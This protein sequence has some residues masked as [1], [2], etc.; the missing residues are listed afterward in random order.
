MIIERIEIRA[1]G[2]L[3]DVTL[4]TDRPVTLV[5]GPNEA[6]KS[7]VL[8]FIRTMLFG[9]AF[10][11]G[12][13]RYAPDPAVIQ[14]GALTLR[15]A[16]GR[17]IRVERWDRSPDG[18]GKSP[19]AGEVKVMFPD[20]TTGGEREL[21][22]LVGG[23][24]P[25]LFRQ[26]FAFG[27]SELQ[28][29][30]TLQSEE[31]S[32]F[33]Y[34][35]GLGLSGTAIRGAQKKL[36]QELEQL[37]RPRGRTPLVNHALRELAAV[38]E[39]LRV[40]RTEAETYRL[41]V[42]DGAKLAERCDAL[43]E[44]LERL[45]REAREL[46]RSRQALQFAHRLEEVELELAELPE[47]LDDVPEDAVLREEAL[48][49]ELERLT[50]E[51]DAV[52]LAAAEAETKLALLESG[53]REREALLARQ[54]E[55]ESLLD[56]LAGYEEGKRQ[57]AEAEAEE[58]QLGLGLERL[59]RRIGPGWTI[60]TL[61][62]LPSTVMLREQAAAYRDE[63]RAW[64][65]EEALIAAE[66]RR[67]EAEASGSYP[68]TNGERV[69]PSPVMFTGGETA[70]SALERVKAARRLFGEWKDAQR[71]IRYA[72]QRLR[73]L[74]LI[75]QG[76]ANGAGS[77]GLNASVGA[78]MLAV[79]YALTVVLPAALLLLGEATA[80][81]VALGLLLGASVWAT[82]N[83]SR[84]RK[85]ERPGGRRGRPYAT[86]EAAADGGLAPLEAHAAELAAKLAAELGRLARLGLSPGAAET[87]AGAA[88]A[89]GA[90]AGRAGAG[91][92][93][94]GGVSAAGALPLPPE[95]IEPWLDAL[96]RQLRAREALLAGRHA[97][98]ER[99]A[100]L[101][102][103]RER[104][105]LA[106]EPLAARWRAW[107]REQALPEAASA[108][109][110]LE[111]LQQAETALGE[112]QRLRRVCA[113]RD[114]LGRAADAFAA[115]ASALLGSPEA[116]R[117]PGAALKARQAEA[118]RALERER[119]AE[120]GRR[121]LEELRRTL[122][123]LEQQLARVRERRRELYRAAGADSGEALRRL[124]RQAQR[125]REL[126]RERR[127]EATALRTLLGEAWEQA[128]EPLRSRSEH[129]LEAEAAA[130]EGA[131]GDLRRRLEETREARSRNRFEQERLADGRGH[132]D[133]LQLAE[134]RRAEL[135]QLTR[136]WAVYALCSHLIVQTKRLFE[137]DKQPFVMQRASQDFAFIT[138]G[139]FERMLA[140]I[141]EQ[142]VLAQ[143]P[144]GGF[145]ETSRLSRGTAEQMYI[146][147]RFAL[148]DEFAGN[149]VRLPLVMDDLFVNFDD[150]RLALGL[151]L[152]K[153][154]SERGQLLLF[155]C[156]RHVVDAYTE[157]FTAESVVHLNRQHK[158]SAEY[159]YKQDDDDRFAVFPPL[160]G[161]HNNAG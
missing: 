57:L 100:A 44:E 87:A 159:P 56:R 140:P 26:L 75:G 118:S 149:G 158:P 136:R 65:Q 78:G 7:T 154:V 46:D 52:N 15:D 23:L 101:R 8:E 107:L 19:A 2:S 84:S 48:E 9:F 61:D 73:D 81:V 110:A 82:L 151:E 139:R 36:T 4:H 119:E 18:R 111:L 16:S 96:E 60:G 40:S 109:A 50:T 114:A 69:D 25:E 74:E 142:R 126:L 33:L 31:V 141:G 130:L 120:A 24:T 112:L 41:L 83:R 115:E 54:G 144:D 137:Q 68:E 77:S 145:V 6:G 29:L 160:S 53:R 123:L 105:A 133:L 70:A 122:A 117:E 127:Q 99:L 92:S 138:G 3:R 94:A 37:Y 66:I 128:L 5:Y 39:R 13:T 42:E 14:G 64:Q 132:A 93:G 55:L 76:A 28:E 125:R 89:S 12:T 80:A 47:A 161:G 113:R 148:V 49:A 45:Q 88:G 86:A 131:I 156:H 11:E 1:Y 62:R 10:R 71:E 155:T 67:L 150:A 51:W 108:E 38:E 124:V 63:W 103:Q 143:R 79:V 30:G 17:R 90:G 34:S 106:G 98:G 58:E 129:E 27:L 20:G 134:E 43:E 153:R 59:L 147:I 21:A 104:H 95:D 102:A 72:E 32:G 97:A 91:V 85:P 157:R 135:A 146:C 22:A 152:L 116:A 121:Q 35:A